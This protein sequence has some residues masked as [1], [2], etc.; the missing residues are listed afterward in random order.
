MPSANRFCRFVGGSSAK[1]SGLFSNAVRT[2]EIVS[3][4]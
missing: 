3:R 4:R 1:S 2:I